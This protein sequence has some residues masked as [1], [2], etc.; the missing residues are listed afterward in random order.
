MGHLGFAL[1]HVWVFN[2]RIE[3]YDNG[4]FGDAWSNALI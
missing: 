1:G 3:T 2:Q 4:A